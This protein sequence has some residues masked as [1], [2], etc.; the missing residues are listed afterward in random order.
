MDAVTPRPTFRRIVAGL[1]TLGVALQACLLAVQLSVIAGPANGATEFAVNVICTD[2]GVQVLPAD[3]TPGHQHSGCVFC[4]FCLNAGAGNLAILP[5]AAIV[6]I[7]APARGLVFDID[8]DL[9]VVA[10]LAH[11]PSRGPPERA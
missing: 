4:P 6:A 8:R 2:H 7:V 9:H 11:P 10:F 1:T 3:G 5:N